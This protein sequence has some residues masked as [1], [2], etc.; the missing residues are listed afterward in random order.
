VSKLSVVPSIS[1]ASKI[2]L[3]RR[4]K[5]AE[6]TKGSMILDGFAKDVTGVDSY[7]NE[8]NNLLN[9]CKRELEV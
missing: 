7:L 1:E 6:Y 4:I 2:R 5:T 9:K 8:L 3:E